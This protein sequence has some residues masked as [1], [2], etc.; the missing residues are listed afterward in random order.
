MKNWPTA[1]FASATIL[2]AAI[3]FAAIS[4]AISQQRGASFMMAA[5]SGSYSWRINTV[6]GSISYCLRRTDSSDPVYISQNPPICSAW[7]PVVE[8]LESYK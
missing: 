7:T 2:A 8:G 3:L 5:G 4:P 1:L 6:T